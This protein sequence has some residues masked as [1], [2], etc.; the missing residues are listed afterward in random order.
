MNIENKTIL[1]TGG[2]TGIGFSI[3]NI[4]SGKGNRIILA[5]RREDKLKEAAGATRT[6]ENEVRTAEQGQALPLGDT[7]AQMVEGG[8]V[9][10]VAAAHIYDVNHDGGR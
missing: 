5:G 3:A 10:L 2:G 7:Q 8:T 4:L 1:I 6:I 9:T